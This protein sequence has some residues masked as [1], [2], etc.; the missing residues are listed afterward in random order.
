MIWCLSFSLYVVNINILGFEGGYYG[1][2]IMRLWGRGYVLG[3][4]GGV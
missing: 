2:C 1:G 3:V 4:V